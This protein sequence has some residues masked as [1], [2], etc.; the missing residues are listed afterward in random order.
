MAPMQQG[1]GHRRVHASREPAEDPLATDC[2]AVSSGRMDPGASQYAHPLKQ[3]A[4]FV[5]V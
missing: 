3:A 2:G 4:F 5:G 1:R